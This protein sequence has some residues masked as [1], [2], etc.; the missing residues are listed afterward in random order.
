MMA[1]AAIL[2]NR[3]IAISWPRYEQFQRKLARGD[4]VRHSWPFEPSLLSTIALFRLM[5]KAWKPV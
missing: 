1:A 2:K 3:K 5:I 4:A